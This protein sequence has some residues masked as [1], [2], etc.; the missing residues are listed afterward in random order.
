YKYPQAAFP[1]CRLIEENRRRGSTDPE[2]EL[3]DTGIFED[4]RY[5]DIFVEYAKAAP[6][7]LC[8]RIEAINRGPEPAPLHLLPHLWFRNTWRWGKPAGH[9][10]TIRPGSHGKAFI[11]LVTEDSLVETL[12]SIPV[13]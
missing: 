12:S 6:E 7:D 9:Q 2:Y 10:P 13:T 8:L 11:S 4:D 1:Y 5:F 3:L